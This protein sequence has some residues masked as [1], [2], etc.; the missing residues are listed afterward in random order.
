MR[1]TDYLRSIAH[2]DSQYNTVRHIEIQSTHRTSYGR[3]RSVRIAGTRLP[4]RL[5][6]ARPS[7]QRPGGRP[8]NRSVLHVY[9]TNS[10]YLR[11]TGRDATRRA[12]HP[13]AQLRVA[14]S[15]SQLSPLG[16]ACMLLMGSLSARYM[17]YISRPRSGPQR[18]APTSTVATPSAALWPNFHTPPSK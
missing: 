12:T 2:T 4:I 7:P 16:L 8:P 13:R 10:Q 18:W 9:C 3:T 11:A 14:P 5:P 1:K 15:R 17:Q 6:H